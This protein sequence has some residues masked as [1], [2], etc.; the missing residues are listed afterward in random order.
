ML[1]IGA[2]R[3]AVLRPPDT[4]KRIPQIGADVPPALPEPT[5]RDRRRWARYL[6]DERAEARV[7]RELAQRRVGEERAI[8]LALADAE[9]R[10]EAHWVELLGGEPARLPHPVRFDLRA[11]ARPERRGALAL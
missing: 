3:A 2:F 8:L 5:A 1:A 11:R 4:V 7:Y 10:H 6:V 9:G